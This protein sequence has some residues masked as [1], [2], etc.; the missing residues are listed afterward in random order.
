MWYYVLLNFRDFVLRFCTTHEVVKL[1]LTSS[2][3]EFE[4]CK[5]CLNVQISVDATNALIPRV[6]KRIYYHFN[7]FMI[8]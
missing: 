4:K 5:I 2:L 3:V 8:L 7:I 6:E 1:F